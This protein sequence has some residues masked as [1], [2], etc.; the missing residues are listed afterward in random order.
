VQGAEAS[1]DVRHVWM[2]GKYGCKSSPQ[3]DEVPSSVQLRD[4]N[5]YATKRLQQRDSLVQNVFYFLAGAS[6]PPDFGFP[7][8]CTP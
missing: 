1:M 2:Q 7:G 8:K 4:C 3:G 6:V 5:K